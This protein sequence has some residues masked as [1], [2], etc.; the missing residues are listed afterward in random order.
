QSIS[1]PEG[2]RFLGNLFW[3]SSGKFLAFSGRNSSNTKYELYVWDSNGK[4]VN[5]VGNTI[6]NIRREGYGDRHPPV[7]WLPLNQKLIYIS[8]ED[9]QHKKANKNP[10]LTP[11]Y[12]PQWE[13]SES[14]LEQ[15]N[16]S[17]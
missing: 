6:P 5:K 14:G 17:L 15:G 4:K 9:N 3:D 16:D 1:I 2:I 12:G 7:F 11:S 10:Q 13:S 8:H